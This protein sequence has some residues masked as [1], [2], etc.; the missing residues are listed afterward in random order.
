MHVKYAFLH[1]SYAV[2]VRVSIGVCCSLF[3]ARDII[4]AVAVRALVVPVAARDVVAV[5]P[6]LRAPGCCVAVAA[7]DAIGV[8]VARAV[9]ARD[10]F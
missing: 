9:A 7:R 5:R 10:V 6:D 2:P 1:C 3:A 8:V 4:G